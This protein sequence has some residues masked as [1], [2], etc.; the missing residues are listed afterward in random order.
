MTKVILLTGGARSG[1]STH[2]LKLANSY[3]RKFFIAT[4]EALDE[5]MTARIAFHRETRP[6]DFETIEEP[7]KV[8]R[9][10]E[11]LEGRADVVVID[12]LT[13]WVSNLMH[14]LSGD[15]LI[16]AEAD[17]LARTLEHAS[18]ASIVVTD[19]VGMG[20]V[21]MHPVERRYRDLLGWTSQKIARVADEVL[22]MVAG[23]P[24]RV[25]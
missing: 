21:P 7:V 19:E 12:C 24:L 9:E 1:K 14:T 5:E 23:Y 6:P 2:A 10:I 13:L 18:F 15:E 20:I 25:K 3:R 22:L 17:A 16:L 4:G 11:S 8:A